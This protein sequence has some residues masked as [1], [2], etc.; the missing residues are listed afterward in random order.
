[1]KRVCLLSLLALSVALPLK[2]FRPSDRPPLPNFD[3]REAGAA[4]HSKLSPGKA[5]AAARLKERVQ[6]LK[7][8]VDPVVGSPKF[9]SSTWDFLSGPDGLGKGISAQF[10][11][12]IPA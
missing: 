9:V 8:D 11:R 7:V 6:G 3:K 4:L 10:Q 5:E 12:A 1:M 2:A